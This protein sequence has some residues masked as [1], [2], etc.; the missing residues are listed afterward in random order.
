MFMKKISIYL[1]FFSILLS[2]SS[3]NDEWEDELYVKM[4]SFKAPVDKM[5]RGVI[6]CPFLSVAQR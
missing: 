2:F 6:I 3:C 5:V 4:V 1:V